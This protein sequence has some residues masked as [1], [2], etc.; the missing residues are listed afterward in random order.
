LSCF[1]EQPLLVASWNRPRAVDIYFL[2][3]PLCVNAIAR[4]NSESGL[5]FPAPQGLSETK[6]RGQLIGRQVREPRCR[7]RMITAIWHDIC[8]ADRLR[9]SDL[10]KTGHRISD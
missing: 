5:K 8:D 4:V 3:D 7:S 10:F 6:A 1:A 2:F 9:M